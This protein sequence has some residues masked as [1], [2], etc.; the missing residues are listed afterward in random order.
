MSTLNNKKYRVQEYI[1]FSLDAA[2]QYLR[3]AV[4]EQRST[5][6][7]FA[8]IKLYYKYAHDSICCCEGT[9]LLA[10]KTG[11]RVD[12]AALRELKEMHYQIDLFIF[13]YELKV[14]E[15]EAVLKT[16]MNGRDVQPGNKT[17]N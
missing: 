3:E 1:E 12:E 4:Q 14:G 17:L 11:V 15:L 9:I 8:K 2:T 7:D 13:T 6:P 16:R 5:K 10:I